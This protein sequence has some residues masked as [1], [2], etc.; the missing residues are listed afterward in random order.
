M[1]SRRQSGCFAIVYSGQERD[2]FSGT[3]WQRS[4]V[5]IHL[6]PNSQEQ[7]NEELF[8]REQEELLA[9]MAKGPPPD[10]PW[11]E[12]CY[13]SRLAWLTFVGPSPGGH[14]INPQPGPRGQGVM[15][16]WNGEYLDPCENW[17]KGFR[18]STQIF[19]ETI[20]NRSREHGALKLY[21]F[22][23]F[24]WV[25]NPNASNVPE[26][27]MRQGS[28]EV[29]NHLNSVKPRVILTMERR[30]HKLLTDIVSKQ[31]TICRPPFGN[32]QLLS[33]ITRNGPKYHRQI[34]AYAI[35]GRGP[36]DGRFVLR[37]PQ[38]P[39]RIFNRD[40]ADRVAHALRHVFVCMAIREKPISINE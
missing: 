18:I 12:G 25:P 21:N 1:C 20:L 3:G 29:I 35:R 39:A 33:V 19:V 37:C 6:A 32:I 26:E 9:K 23:N 40:Y 17:S 27:R 13:G 22:A 4:M 14:N 24:D 36:L 2:F 11:P 8:Q 15:P 38:H 10:E 34:D 28:N 7:L 16:L 31:Y 5:A 30:A